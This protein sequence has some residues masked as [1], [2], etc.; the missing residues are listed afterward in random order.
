[1]FHK[2]RK[3]TVIFICSNTYLVLANLRLLLAKK[4]RHTLRE[5]QIRLKS[6]FP[7]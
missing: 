1:M 6:G 2:K 5:W 4:I 3:K 7:S